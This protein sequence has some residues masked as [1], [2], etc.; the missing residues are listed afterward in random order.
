MK[1][2][3]AKP[4]NEDESAERMTAK[5]R[6]FWDKVQ[7]D[8]DEK[9]AALYGA[10]ITAS[11]FDSPRALMAFARFVYLTEDRLAWVSVMHEDFTLHHYPNGVLDA[12]NPPDDEA[13]QEPVVH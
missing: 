1:P 2:T 9:L 12:P 4:R 11:G 10:L 7:G 8:D 6:E 3:K 5:M 13:D